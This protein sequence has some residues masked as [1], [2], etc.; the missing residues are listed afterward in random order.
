MWCPLLMLL[1]VLKVHQ[2]SGDQIPPQLCKNGEAGLG[3]WTE[4]RSLQRSQSLELQS[5]LLPGPSGLTPHTGGGREGCCV[6]MCVVCMCVF[7]CE[8]T[9]VLV[10]ANG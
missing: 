8:L 5:L 9:Y 2:G 1:P 6:C 3:D 4:K 7:M 10:G